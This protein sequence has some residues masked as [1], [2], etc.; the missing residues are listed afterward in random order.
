MFVFSDSHVE[1]AAPTLL[2]DT[3]TGLLPPVMD[4]VRYLTFTDGRNTKLE[5]QTRPLS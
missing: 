4:L 1:K 2:P 5:D 3:F